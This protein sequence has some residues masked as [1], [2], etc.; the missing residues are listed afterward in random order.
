MFH[1]F[2]PLMQLLPLRIRTANE[3]CVNFTDSSLEAN[4]ERYQFFKDWITK[5]FDI[6]LQFTADETK[7]PSHTVLVEHN[8]EQ[9]PVLPTATIQDVPPKTTAPKSSD[10]IPPQ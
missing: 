2:K 7:K 10:Q 8:H 4:K 9:L 3:Q 1:V 5:Q 6:L